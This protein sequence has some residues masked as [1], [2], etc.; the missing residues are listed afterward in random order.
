MGEFARKVRKSTLESALPYVSKILRLQEK[1][2]ELKERQDRISE[3]QEQYEEQKK[4]G[5]NNEGFDINEWN[6]AYR[7]IKNAREVIKEELTE[8]QILVSKLSEYIFGDNL[9]LKLRDDEIKVEFT[10]EYFYFI[11]RER[12]KWQNLF[13]DPSYF[14]IMACNTFREEKTF[15]T[16]MLNNFYFRR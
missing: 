10:K 5:E 11:Q 15:L 14:I 4:R 7:R 3:K 8:L 12:V 1:E 6:Q 2:N 13:E 16:T 9:E